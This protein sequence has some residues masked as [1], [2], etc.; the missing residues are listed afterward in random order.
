MN[1][2]HDYYYAKKDTL[3]RCNFILQ[4]IVITIVNYDWEMFIVQAP[5]CRN[6]CILLALA[7]QHK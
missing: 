5:E 3:L 6:D 1:Q 2:I 4:S 7:L